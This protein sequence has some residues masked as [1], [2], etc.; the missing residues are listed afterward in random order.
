MDKNILMYT[1]RKLET[2]AG[3]VYGGIYFLIYKCPIKNRIAFTKFESIDIMDTN[4]YI[5]TQESEN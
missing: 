1:E 4:I 3:K 2:R 5:F